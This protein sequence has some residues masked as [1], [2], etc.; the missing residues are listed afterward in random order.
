MIFLTIPQQ[1]K[2]Y[3]DSAYKLKMNRILNT[4]KTWQEASKRWM[5]RYCL[6]HVIYKTQTHRGTRDSSNKR[7]M[8]AA[9]WPWQSWWPVAPRCL[10][11][12]RVEQY[13]SFYI[14]HT[15]HCVANYSAVELCH[16]CGLLWLV[17]THPPTTQPSTIPQTVPDPLQKWKPLPGQECLNSD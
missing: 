12:C 2:W 1:W 4:E 9:L 16:L 17:T 3:L 8:S 13:S 6:E 11:S 14:T 10:C 15:D 5:T 7:V